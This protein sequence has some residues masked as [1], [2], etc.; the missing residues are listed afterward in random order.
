MAQEREVGWEQGVVNW[1]EERDSHV[2]VKR[3]AC[4]LERA[5]TAGCAV[6][7][8]ASSKLDG[9]AWPANDS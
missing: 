3:D 8:G 6:D 1:G 5:S 9:E 2:L 4:G 7:D